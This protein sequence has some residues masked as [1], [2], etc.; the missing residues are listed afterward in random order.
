MRQNHFHS[1]Q[2]PGE[3]SSHRKHV[4]RHLYIYTAI[5]VKIYHPEYTEE[6][7]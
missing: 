7:K 1:I 4:A 3:E 5:F 6:R 2:E